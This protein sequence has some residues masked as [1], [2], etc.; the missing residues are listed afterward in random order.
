M[1]QA[2]ATVNGFWNSFL[3][4]YFPFPEYVISPEK[5]TDVLANASREGRTDLTITRLAGG[6]DVLFL[7]GKKADVWKAPSE[8]EEYMLGSDAGDGV[9]GMAV[10]GR[11]VAFF[12]REGGLQI[13]N[14]SIFK[15][16]IGKTGNFERFNKD[17]M[18]F[19]NLDNANDLA[20]IHAI[21]SM[22]THPKPDLKR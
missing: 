3:A 13:G 12:Q 11:S 9:Y 21:L 16:G 2:E 1:L 17:D 18:L 15:V 4:D 22:W 14:R 10:S 8:V 7:E 19:Y 20:A 5:W 6:H